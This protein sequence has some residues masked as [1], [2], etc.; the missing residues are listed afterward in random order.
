MAPG[1]DMPP[2]AFQGTQH[3]AI[4]AS[5]SAPGSSSSCGEVPVSGAGLGLPTQSDVG[6]A[7]AMDVNGSEDL[8]YPTSVYD[9]PVKP[10]H[11]GSDASEEVEVPTELFEPPEDVA[12]DDDMEV[13]EFVT[14]VLPNLGNAGSVSS[15]SGLARPV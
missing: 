6:D 5:A 15:A 12:R 2:L 10:V 3:T 1:L 14:S 8:D 9:S 11:D 13:V 7:N 4:A